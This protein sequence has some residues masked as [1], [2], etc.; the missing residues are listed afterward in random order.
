MNKNFVFL[1]TPKFAADILLGLINNDWLPKLV[2]T[3]PPKPVGRNKT[4]TASAVSQLASQHKLK[5]AHPQTKQKLTQLLL[6]G[7]FDFGIV[8][9]YGRLIPPQAVK[10]TTHGLI[11]IHGSLLP[12]YRGASPVQAAILNGET[13]TGVSYMV[14]E[15]GLDTGPVFAMHK[16]QIKPDDTT[17]SLLNGLAELVNKTLVQDVDD[18]LTGKLQAE[19]QNDNLT[20]STS[21]IKKTD[22]EI[23]LSQITPKELDCKLR[24]YTPW[25][26]IYTE[27]FGTRLIIRAGRLINESFFISELQW[28]GKSPVNGAVFAQ[29]NP[30]ILTQLPKTIKID[31]IN[32]YLDKD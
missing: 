8:V 6:K 31:A 24:A 11:N 25:P 21:L 18:F 10:V 26:G 15:P 14:I 22:G 20:T 27:Q 23:N 3:E 9:A 16:I 4:L 12:K 7:G 29:A 32:W 13:E 1:G 5:V 17:P 19:A 28:A 30:E 2:I